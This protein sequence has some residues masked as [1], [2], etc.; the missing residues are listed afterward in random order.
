MKKIMVL[1]TGVLL[2]GSMTFATERERPIVPAPVT[3]PISWEI[4]LGSQ[5]FDYDEKH[6]KFENKDRD[7]YRVEYSRR[8]W[9]REAELRRLREIEYRRF[10]EREYKRGYR[11]GHGHFR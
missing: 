10:L 8:D 9:R 4:T 3:N 11:R 7:C 6:G 1:F 5:S 2:V